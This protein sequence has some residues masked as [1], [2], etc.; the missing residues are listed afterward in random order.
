MTGAAMA[1]ATRTAWITG[2]GSGIGRALALRL[3]GDGWR[4]AVSARTAAD[5]LQL[6][7]EASEMAGTIVPFPLDVRDEAAIRA[8][9]AEMAERFG[10]IDRVV[11]NAGTHIPMGLA[12]FASGPARTLM[13]VNYMGVVN[14]LAAVLPYLTRQGWGQVAVVSSVAG[15]GGLPTAA[16]Y[17]PTKAALINLCESLRPECE[18]AGIDLRLI[19]PG[20]VDTPL[21]RRNDFPMPALVG[22][23]DAAA[24]IVRGLDGRRFETAFPWGFTRFLKLL[25]LLPYRLYFALSGRL[26]RP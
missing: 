16:A 26:V 6:A 2:A 10:A 7:A 1:G 15:Y 23:E 21:T 17:G 14:G 8:A 3:A 20:F 11:L 5:L 18:R 13:E 4:V 22:A 25:R 12:D 19:C 24:A 9:V